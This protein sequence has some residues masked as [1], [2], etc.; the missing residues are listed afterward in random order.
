MDQENQDSGTPSP[1]PELPLN[2][3]YPRI[4]PIS[5]AFIGLIGGFFLYQ[6]MGGTM[7]LLIFGSDLSAAPA[8]GVRLITMAGQILFILLPA[9][10]LSKMVYEDVT[11]IIR[12]RKPDYKEVLLFCAGI[13]ILTPLLQYYLY[14]QNY[15]LAEWA[16]FSPFI[17][18]VKTLFD[19]LNE[20]V[21]GAY[22]NLLRANNI[23]EALLVVIVIAVVPA[24]TEEV[25][26]RGYIQRSF[27]F[28]FKPVWAALF[29]AIFFGLFHFNF[30]GL[31]PLIALGFYFGFAA[32][33]T[34]S[35]FVPV[36]LHFL[37]NFSAVMLFFIF[38]DEELI[39]SASVPE[40]ELGSSVFMFF[41][42]LV[43]FI[44]II[45]F[46]RNYSRKIKRV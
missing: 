2:N 24:I 29:T 22:G 18:S 23:F 32:Y 15:F 34:N 5:A 6:V 4:S 43:L 44:G 40:T 13:I 9:L 35:I 28:K 37:N 10:I 12:F 26:F 20:M 30:Y 8:N 1:N 36:F 25:M 11:E 39:N 27:E 16:K 3:I 33:T 31:I 45:G 19:S 46:I 7:H 42:F 38:G 41:V 14:I 21:E 17:N